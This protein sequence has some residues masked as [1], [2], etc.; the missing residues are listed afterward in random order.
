MGTKPSFDSVAALMRELSFEEQIALLNSDNRPGLKEFLQ[1]IGST[2]VC[3]IPTKNKKRY[4]IDCDADPFLPAG[5]TVE[6]HR[7]GGQLDWDVIKAKIQL[8]LSKEQQDGKDIQGNKL[9]KKIEK[10]AKKKALNANVLDFWLANPH[11][12]PDIW[13]GKYIY[14]W[15][16]IYRDSSGRLCVRCLY[17]DGDRWCWYYRW[18]DCGLGGSHPAA[19]LKS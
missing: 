16:T 11:L 18:F 15:G 1:S 17:G 4:I 9:R 3:V 14:F 7:K 12:I 8:Y 2:N 13:K 6:K 19:V 5:W 10:L